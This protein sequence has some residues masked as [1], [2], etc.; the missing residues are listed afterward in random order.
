MN[1]FIKILINQFL[2]DHIL[3]YIFFIYSSILYLILIVFWVNKCKSIKVS[4]FIYLATTCTWISRLLRTII[5][6]L[7]I[8]HLIILR[9]IWMLLLNIRLCLCNTVVAT[10]LWYIISII[11]DILISIYSVGQL[12][13]ATAW[14]ATT[15]CSCIHNHITLNMLL[16][17]FLL[18]LLLLSA[19]FWTVLIRSKACCAWSSRWITSRSAFNLRRLIISWRSLW[20]NLDLDQLD[21]FI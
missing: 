17:L 19:W 13:L 4:I 18:L 21:Q 9:I 12:N 3:R 20:V 16:K 2:S 15:H 14:A 6:R 11:Y 10:L 8:G 7:A 5:V 1:Y